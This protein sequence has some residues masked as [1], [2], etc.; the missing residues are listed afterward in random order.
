MV[1][2]VGE[3]AALKHCRRRKARTVSTFF[4]SIRFLAESLFGSISATLSPVVGSEATKGVNSYYI[5]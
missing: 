1:P 3:L 5:H 4:A 2:G